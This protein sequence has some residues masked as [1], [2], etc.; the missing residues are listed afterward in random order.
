MPSAILRLRL[1]MYPLVDDSIE[2]DINPA[3]IEITTSRSS[4]PVGKKRK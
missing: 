2:I 3:D 4:E 1:F